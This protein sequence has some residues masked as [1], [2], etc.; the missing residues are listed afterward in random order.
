VVGQQGRV[1]HSP[2]LVGVGKGGANRGEWGGVRRGDSRVSRQDQSV[3]GAENAGCAAS[4]H[5]VHV[6]GVVV[7]GD[8]VVHGRLV[9]GR[10]EPR[11]WPARDGDR[12]GRG[13]RR[14]G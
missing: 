6:V 11:E 3:D 5:R 10:R 9:A 12:Q 7:D 14:S 8:Q 4:H 2:K 13:R 1:L